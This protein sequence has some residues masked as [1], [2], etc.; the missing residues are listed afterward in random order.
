MS[1][2]WPA[3]SPDLLRH[4]GKFEPGGLQTF[5]LAGCGFDIVSAGELDVSSPP[6]ETRENRVFRRRKTRE[7]MHSAWPL[8]AGVMCFNVESEAELSDPV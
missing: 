6:G 4:E 5:R 7:E 3:R 1:A 2:H 8:Q